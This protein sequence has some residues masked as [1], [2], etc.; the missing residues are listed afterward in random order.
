MSSL[1]FYLSKYIV[2]ILILLILLYIGKVILFIILLNSLATE[3][4]KN[5]FVDLAYSLTIALFGLPISQVI[6]LAIGSIYVKYQI[7]KTDGIWFKYIKDCAN[8]KDVTS[9]IFDKIE[10]ESPLKL[11]RWWNFEE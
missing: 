11:V 5:V 8:I 6:G 7:H 1:L 9:F 2:L 10:C 3:N 4:W